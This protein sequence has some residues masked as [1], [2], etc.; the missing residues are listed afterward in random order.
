MVSPR[1]L[2]TLKYRN[3]IINI[4]LNK[5]EHLRWLNYMYIY[6]SIIC[7]IA[8]YSVPLYR[9]HDGVSIYMLLSNVLFTILHSPSDKQLII[10]QNFLSI[11]LSLH[12]VL[13]KNLLK[14]EKHIY[15]YQTPILWLSP[16]FPY[17]RLNKDNILL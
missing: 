9:F 5:I 10:W 1:F 2:R 14:L 8:W 13:L 7:K 11:L 4:K 15:I 6:L 3:I 12:K 16:Y 17:L